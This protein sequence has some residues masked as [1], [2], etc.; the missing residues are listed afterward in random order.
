VY[1]GVDH[2]KATAGPATVADRPFLACIGADF[3]HKNRVF[4]IRLRRELA[5]RGFDA[6]L[7]LAGA[8][9]EH[10]SSHDEEDAEGLGRVVRLGQVSEAQKRWLYENAAL[11]L[12]PTVSEGFGLVPFEAAAAGTPCMFAPVSSL[13]E[14]AGVENATLVPWSAAESADR[15]LTLVEEE[16]AARRLVDALA[17]RGRA[18]TW[19]RAA[20]ALVEIYRDIVRRPAQQARALYF[21]DALSDTA[22]SL[23]GPGGQLPADVQKALLAIAARPALRRP[24]FALLR[25]P[26]RLLSRARRRR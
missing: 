25:A 26:Y 6:T 5:Q 15:A 14:V 4:A 21:G 17:E 11:V 24:A 2:A 10:G 3:R 9:V 12:Y 18:Y 1:P 8:H 13:P 23:V 20:A 16:A 19:D 7:V 22:L